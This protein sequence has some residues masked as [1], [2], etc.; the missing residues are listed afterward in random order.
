MGREGRFAFLIFGFE[1][2][3]SSKMDIFSE[4]QLRD[5]LYNTA[6]SWFAS[7][8]KYYLTFLDSATAC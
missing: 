8:P 5:G 1:I 6:F 4:V 2:L 7:R 3:K